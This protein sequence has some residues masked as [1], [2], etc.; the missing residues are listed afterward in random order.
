MINSYRIMCW[1]PEGRGR[2]AR[3]SLIRKD[4]IK[5]NL[6]EIV[7]QGVGWIQECQGKDRWRISVALRAGNFFTV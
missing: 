5:M 1:K 6:K 4:N 7:R 3:S 2:L